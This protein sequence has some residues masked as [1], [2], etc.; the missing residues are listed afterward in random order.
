M[1]NVPARLATAKL[2][3]M[4]SLLPTVDEAI[5]A[6]IHSQRERVDCERVPLRR[7]VAPYGGWSERGGG[8]RGFRLGKEI[9]LQQVAPRVHHRVALLRGLDA[10][11]DHLHL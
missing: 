9:S 6:A 7:N 2:L 1:S 3:F 11:R 5:V 8:K 4:V 10:L